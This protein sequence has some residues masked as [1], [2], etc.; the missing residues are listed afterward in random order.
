[1]R[2]HFFPSADDD[3]HRIKFRAPDNLTHWLG[4]FLVGRWNGTGDL[5]VPCACHQSRHGRVVA[6]TFFGYVVTEVTDG[7]LIGG[8]LDG[9]S[10]EYPPSLVCHTS[11]KLHMGRR[12]CRSRSKWCSAILCETVSRIPASIQ[13]EWEYHNTTTLHRT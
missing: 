12:G 2:A 1:M 13:H 4:E 10:I 11:S 8:V 9:P 5:L 7:K 3:G 6:R